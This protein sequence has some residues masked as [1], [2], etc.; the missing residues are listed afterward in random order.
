MGGREGGDVRERGTGVRKE[1][2]RRGK[3]QEWRGEEEGWKKKWREG[4][5]ERGER[6]GR[7]N[8]GKEGR[9]EGR[10]REDGRERG[11]KIER[12][13]GSVVPGGSSPGSLK[14]ASCRECVSLREGR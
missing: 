6:A 7:K 1:E 5:K 12:R 4:R 3:L 11:E 14:S 2:A 9:R 10:G 13:E 8:V